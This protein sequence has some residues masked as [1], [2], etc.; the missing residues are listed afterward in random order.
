MSETFYRI[1]SL[2]DPRTHSVRYVGLTTLPLLDRLVD[3]VRAPETDNP[4][5]FAWIRDLLVEGRVPKIVE[6]D[7][8]TDREEALQYE[9]EWISKARSLHEDLLNVAGSLEWKEKIAAPQRSRKQSPDHRQKNSL[10]H[11]GQIVTEEHRKKISSSL[12]GRK[13]TSEH[14]AKISEANR[15]RSRRPHG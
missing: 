15:R 13:F 3:H 10:S 4:K 6:V 8:F 1:Y 5:K 11:R 2:I 14:R 12:K 7:L 9:R